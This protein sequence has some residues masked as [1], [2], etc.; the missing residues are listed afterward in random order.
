MMPLIID[1][2]GD[3]VRI[4]RGLLAAASGRLKA[5]SDVVDTKLE[6]ILRL[7]KRYYEV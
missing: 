1:A 7:I 3:L 6:V 2:Q 4:T 5:T